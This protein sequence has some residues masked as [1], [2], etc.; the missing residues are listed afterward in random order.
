MNRNK[1]ITIRVSESEL[2]QVREMAGRRRKSVAEYLRWLV[3][4]DESVFGA[5]VPQ[6][7]SVDA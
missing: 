4:R 3:D 7:G 2:E 1:L 5:D 6:H